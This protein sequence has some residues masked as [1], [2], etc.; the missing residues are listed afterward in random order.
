MF[1][2]K[3]VEGLDE[4]EEG[5]HFERGVDMGELGEETGEEGAGEEGA[6]PCIGCVVGTEGGEDGRRGRAECE[7][8]KGGL[9][10]VVEGLDRG[11]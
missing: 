10:E 8:V 11:G 4:L 3:V 7:G 5:A 2:T 1:G 9:E 6:V